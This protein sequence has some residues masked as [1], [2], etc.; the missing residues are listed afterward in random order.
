MRTTAG[1]PAPSWP[2]PLRRCRTSDLS[3]AAH[4]QT[5]GHL[6]GSEERGGCNSLGWLPAQRRSGSSGLARATACGGSSTVEPE[7]AK[8]EIRVR[9][10]VTAPSTL[11]EVPC[12]AQ[13]SLRSSEEDASH[14]R[15]P[16]G[17]TL[18]AA[19]APECESS[20]IRGLEPLGWGCNSLLRNRD[21]P[22]CASSRSAARSIPGRSS[23]SCGAR[24]LVMTPA[25]QAGEGEFDPLAPYRRA[26][27]CQPRLPLEAR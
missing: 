3:S 25:S 18:P 17:S 21:V 6:T 23:R 10:S 27:H 19:T 26:L 13:S 24:H 9:F 14:T 7:H 8:L 5:A 4:A 2:S 1:F 15:G 20:R 16:G 22:V 12:R 11:A